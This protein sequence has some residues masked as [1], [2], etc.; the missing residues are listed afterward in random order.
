MDVEVRHKNKVEHNRRGKIIV[1]AIE[2]PGSSVS[3]LEFC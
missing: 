2:F 3:T 1:G